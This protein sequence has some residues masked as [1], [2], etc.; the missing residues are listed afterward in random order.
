MAALIFS[1]AVAVLSVLVLCGGDHDQAMRI[2]L[3]SDY[4]QHID[5]GAALP[6]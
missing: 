4:R 6:I 3:S 5:L 2:L 1:D